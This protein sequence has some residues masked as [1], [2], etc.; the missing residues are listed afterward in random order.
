MKRP[1]GAPRKRVMD[2]VAS[3]LVAA[4]VSSLLEDTTWL[5]ERSHPDQIQGCIG[6][7]ALLHVGFDISSDISFLHMGALP[8]CLGGVV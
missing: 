5:A 2:E 3:P 4:A 8:S 6:A 1:W 7:I